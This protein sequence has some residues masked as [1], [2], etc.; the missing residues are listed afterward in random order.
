MAATPIASGIRYINVETTEIVYVP[1]IVDKAA[2]T[3][4][5]LDA[6]TDVTCEVMEMSG[7]STTSNQVETPDL[8]SRYTSSIPGR[9]TAEDSSITFYADREGQA[10]QTLLP[11][12]EEGFIV[13]YDTGDQEGANSEV[14]DVYPVTVMSSSKTRSV[15]GSSAASIV[16]Q[17]SITSEPAENVLV[18]SV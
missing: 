16:T 4:T 5:E 9:I 3:R 14:M 8:C 10:I 11:R 17:F 15:D 2:P 13:I 12:N 6:G 18:P 7:F 1:D